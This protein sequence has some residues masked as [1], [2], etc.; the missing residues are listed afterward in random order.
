MNIPTF[1]KKTNYGG[2]MDIFKH[3]PLFIGGWPG[4]HIVY[5]KT[6]RINLV[7]QHISN[8]I[9]QL[10]YKVK[11]I[12]KYNVEVW[13]RGAIVKCGGVTLV[14]LSGREFD[15]AKMIWTAR[16]GLMK[17]RENVCSGEGLYMLFKDD[18]EYGVRRLAEIQREDVDLG[19]LK[20]EYTFIRGPFGLVRKS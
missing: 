15:L 8:T 4:Q 13:D 18:P 6:P 5:V 2:V 16:R 11:H 19:A 20:E 17:E 3:V 7:R 1:R 9:F 14:F 12:D 10:Q